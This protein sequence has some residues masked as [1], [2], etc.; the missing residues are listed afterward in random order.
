MSIVSI[1]QALETALNSITPS[2]QTAWENKP[3]KPTTDIEYQR[4]FILSDTENPTMGGDHYREIGYMQVDLMYPPEDG[5]LPS[6]TRAELIR[7]AFKRGNSFIKDGVTVHISDT[8]KID[9]SRNEDDRYKT[10][11]RIPFFAD[12]C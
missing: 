2:I 9:D 4:V 5:S 6:R 7:D 12:I 11:I 3:F 1:T 8:P 10:I